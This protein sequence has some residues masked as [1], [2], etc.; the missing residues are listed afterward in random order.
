MNTRLSWYWKRSRLEALG[1]HQLPA[2]AGL[3][4]GLLGGG[5]G[6]ADGLGAG[7]GDGEPAGE[8]LT[9]AQGSVGHSVRFL[10]R[11]RF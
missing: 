8:G 10:S 11:L 9:A 2:G 6:A 1:R 5:D 4:A 7:A 3:G